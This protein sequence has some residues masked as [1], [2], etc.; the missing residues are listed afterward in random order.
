MLPGLLLFSGC[1]GRLPHAGIEGVEVADYQ[2]TD[3][4]V[5]GPLTLGCLHRHGVAA[6]AYG[7][8]EWMHVMVPP[9]RSET[10]RHLLNAERAGLGQAEKDSFQMVGQV[11]VVHAPGLDFLKD[12]PSLAEVSLNMTETQF[13]EL[14]QRQGLGCQWEFAGSQRTYWVKPQAHVLVAVGFREGRCSGIQRL[15]D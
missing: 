1:A 14:V 8:G 6:E 4:A 12:L 5:A 9:A 13:L 10:A 3:A 2:T 11:H 15:P 7:V